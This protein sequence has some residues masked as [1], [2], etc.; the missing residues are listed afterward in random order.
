MS[1]KVYKECD[2]EVIKRLERSAQALISPSE[3]QAVH[4]ILNDIKKNGKNAINRYRVQFDRINSDFKSLDETQISEAAAQC[5]PEIQQ[6]IKFSIQNVRKYHA[7]HSGKGEE[8]VQIIDGLECWRK[9]LPI[10]AVGLYVP[11]GSAPLFSSLIMLAVPARLAGCRRIVVCTPPD[12]KGALNPEIAF[13]AKELGLTEIYLIGGAQAVAFM[14]YGC[15]GIEKTDKIFGPGNR[16]VTLAKQIVSSEGIAIDMPAG[17][18]EVLVIADKHAKPEFVASD[19]LSQCEHG[20]DSQAILLS[21]HISL[22]NEVEKQ[23][24]KL[25]A[26]LPRASVIRKSLE[27]SFAVHVKDMQQA[28]ELSNIYAPEHLILAVEKAEELCKQVKNAGSV[29]LGNYSAEV[30]GD[31]VSG[32]NHTLPTA[33]FAK[34]LGGINLESFCKF[35]SFQHVSKE[36]ANMLAK[37]TSLLAKA[38]GLDA[39][40]LAAELRM[41]VL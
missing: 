25:I 35:I 26:K 37:T 6:A 32:P 15:E 18:S 38:E 14:A 22:I 34:T 40:A 36:A 12:L 39:H 33:G 5:L 9:M 3:T 28:S 2:S 27:N 21:D 16:F 1:F 4:Q 29:F 7:S 41:E 24:E 10:H 11:G 8:K 30:F 19:L 13:I 17:P 23:I 31:Y 20:P